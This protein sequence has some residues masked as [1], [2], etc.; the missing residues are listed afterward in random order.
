MD[1]VCFRPRPNA[2]LN[3]TFIEWG[4]K[5]LLK[6]VLGDHVRFHDVYF[7]PLDNGKIPDH[8]LFVVCGTPWIWDQCTLSAKYHDLATALSASKAAKM[9]FGIGACFPFGFECNEVCQAES[10]MPG[11]HNVLAPFS[12]IAVRDRLAKST[13][14]LLGIRTELLC[15][16]AIFAS[17]YIGAECF[18]RERDTLFFY[19]PHLGLSGGVLSERFVQ[20]YLT[21]QVDYARASEAR[22]ICITQGEARVAGELGLDAELLHSPDEVAEKLASAKTLLSGRVHGCVFTSGMPVPA[23]LLAVD[24]RFLTYEYCGGKVLMADTVSTIDSKMLRRCKVNYRKEKKK[25]IRFLKHSLKSAG[26]Y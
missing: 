3:D 7:E 6:E 21:I 11:L 20:H 19:A 5:G 16:P 4:T 26:L 9:A 22:V 25:W 18:E 24:S 14:D 15:C 17:E 13:C 1:V 10:S 8:D 12:G 2:N 23:S